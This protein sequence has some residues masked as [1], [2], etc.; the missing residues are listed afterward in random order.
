[1]I[2][3]AAAVAEVELIL[4]EHAAESGAAWIVRTAACKQ[5]RS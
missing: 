1:M 5:L 4:E 3:P 2:D